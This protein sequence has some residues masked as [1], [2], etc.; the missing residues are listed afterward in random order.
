MKTKHLLFYFFFLLPIYSLLA[1]EPTT[2]NVS[3]SGKISWMYYDLTNQAEL[4]PLSGL[5]MTGK[6]KVKYIHLQISGKDIWMDEFGEL[7]GNI[8]GPF[9]IEYDSDGKIDRLKSGYETIA[10]FR[11]DFDGRLTNVK[12]GNYTSQFSLKYD[13]DGRLTGIDKGNYK[14]FARFSYNFDDDIDRIKDGSYN[15]IYDFRYDWDER[16]E[17]I[18]NKSYDWKAK[19]GYYNE[20]AKNVVYYDIN[21]VILIGQINLDQYLNLDQPSYNGGN[22]WGTTPSNSNCHHP[23]CSGN[24]NKTVTF[25]EHSNHSGNYFSY[26]I[27]NYGVLPSNWN[28][29]ISSIAIPY[30]IKVTIYANSNFS[31]SCKTIEGNW[32]VTSWNDYWNDRISSVKIEL[33]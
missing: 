17:G 28:D 6:G 8:Y 31:G 2:V 10:R 27:G 25:F 26:P 19:I 30:G 18:K 14:Y 4:K 29:K 16:L 33:S 21:S 11:Y 20:Q 32:S 23:C 1:A 9:E 15:T 5:Y 7:K 3:T 22:S 12:D 24:S 13:F